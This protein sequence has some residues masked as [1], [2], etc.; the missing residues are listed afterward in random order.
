MNEWMLIY[1]GMDP[2]GEG[3][4]EALCTLGN[5]YL[6]TRGA[7]PECVADGVHYPGTYAAGIYNRLSSDINGRDVENESLV[8]LPNWLPLRFRYD[9]G[10]WIDE[11]TAE[12]DAHRI[13]LDT[14]RGVLT[15]HT[16]F[17]ESSGRRTRITQRR[18]VSMDD[19]H[20]CGLET[21]IVPLD[22]AGRLEV[23]S[24]LDG[25]VTNSG[26]PR[27]SSL[28]SRHLDPIA[29]TVHGDDTVCLVVE[30]NQSRI[31]I[32]ESARTHVLL[33]GERVAPETT[34]DEHPG[35]VALS[36]RLDVSPGDEVIVEK[37]VAVF[38]SRDDAISEPRL[39][40]CDLVQ[41]A[42]GFDEL[43]E[44]HTV[45]WRHRWNRTQLE[46]GCDGE[47]ARLLNL[48]M[49]HC[50]VTV[51]P[52]SALL[53]VGVPARGLH[54]EAYRGH[55]FWDEMFIF[56]FFSLRVPELT[57]S[58]LF[59]RY[60]RLPQA[61]RLARENGFTGAMFP[62]QS[63]ANGREETQTMHLNP[64]SG[65][66]LQDGSHL[67]RHVNSAIAYNVWQYYQ[68]TGDEEFM[69]FFGAELL[70]EI[71]R[72]WSSMAVYD[73]SLDRYAI[74]GVMGPDEYHEGYPDR[75]GPGLDNNSYTNLMAV[76]C[77][78][79]ALELLKDLPPGTAAELRERLVI[80]QEELDRWGDVSRKMLVC[81]HDSG[82]DG[83]LA[84]PVISQFQG[85]EHLLELDWDGYR[86]RYGDIARLDRILEAEG[87][88]P[89]RYQ[90][91]KQPDVLMLFY[92]L[93]EDELAGLL[94]RLGYE[95]DPGLRRRCIAYYE[96][97]TSH[98]STL[99][100]VVHAWIHAREQ[101]ERS[102]AEFLSAL[103]SDVDDVQGGTTREGI[104]VG[105]MAGTIDLVQRCYTGLELRH[106]ELRLDPVIP[107]ELGS[108]GLNLRYRQHN[109]HL[110]IDDMAVRMKV[111]RSS[112]D[113]TLAVRVRGELYEVKQGEVVEFP[114]V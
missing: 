50:M 70:F 49:F 58:L 103:H 71:A 93:S 78:A 59:Y 16:E 47:V 21:T 67:Q 2:D 87:D 69:R 86:A 83:D 4:R 20:L 63:S 28:P 99:S 98:G 57:R 18:F 7:L 41:V 30:T 55:I 27:Y 68:A 52:H 65:H 110:D 82:L 80:T 19:A 53:D 107:A 112:T 79:R 96:P 42:G 89:D 36:L 15:R 76:W 62:W 105:A 109:L 9:G 34:V 32:A 38:T 91:T 84:G 10:E 44:H 3:L 5:G 14:H 54:G 73:H 88:S 31:R 35:A 90:L 13:E 113:G 22:R 12:V 75:D 95:A 97:R 48:H 102:W 72:L 39:E 100:R 104:H 24:G 1:E 92:L 94:D 43:L 29:T 85:Y 46:P 8:N 25:R 33:N 11:T 23:W 60:R 74:R 51:S 17:R 64:D 101:R 40:A 45:A 56:P 26:V 106:D 111:G 6:A 114:L 108:L 66:W 77:L 81:F 61:R 37:L